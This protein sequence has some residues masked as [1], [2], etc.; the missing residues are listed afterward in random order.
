MLDE[1]WSHVEWGSKYQVQPS[2]L[3]KLLSETKICDLDIEILDVIWYKEDIFWFNVSMCDWLQMH[4][5]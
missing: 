1:L 3:V 5:V 2:A 4:I